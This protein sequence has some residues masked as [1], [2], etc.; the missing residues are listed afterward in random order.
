MCLRMG[1]ASSCVCSVYLMRGVF[2]LSR[3]GLDVKGS[4]L[5]GHFPAYPSQAHS[6]A[7]WSP[8]PLSLLR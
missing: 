4:P 1:G 6:T 3:R 5:L 8:V 2:G 7:L